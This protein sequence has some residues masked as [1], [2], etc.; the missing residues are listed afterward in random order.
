MSEKSKYFII[1][2]LS[3]SDDHFDNYS[4]DNKNFHHVLEH[5]FL[6]AIEQAGFEP[7]T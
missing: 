2:P 5:L 7:Q 3:T 6:S 4:R 1:M